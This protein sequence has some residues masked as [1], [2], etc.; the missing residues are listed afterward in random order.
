M[1]KDKKNQLLAL[2]KK[3]INYFL[4]NK[5]NRPYYKSLKEKENKQFE[6]HSINK[7]TII[8]TIFNHFY[9]Y[10]NKEYFIKASIIYPFCI[11]F[12]LFSSDGIYFLVQILDILRQL[13]YFQRYY[14]YEILTSINKYYI[15]NKKYDNYPNLTKNIIIN[16]LVYIRD[17]IRNNLIIKKEEINNI[18]EKII[19]KKKNDNENNENIIKESN[20]NNNFVYKYDEKIYLYDIKQCIIIKQ[21][22][23]L[24]FTIK[25]KETQFKYIPNNESIFQEIMKEYK[26]Y[27]NKI[28]FNIE[29]YINDN[30]I[31]IIVNIIYNFILLKNEDICLYLINAIILLEKCKNDLKVYKE[32][33]RKK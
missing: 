6:L 30:L 23:S 9:Q 32:N 1:K 3:I 18:I 29:N 27:Y 12:P 13:N 7:S 25:G 5:K 22:N 10:L 20:N 26:N 28:D 4:F 31:E 8:T 24:F 14:L 15:I 33:K 17:Y 21:D 16:H 11:V 2:D 19:L